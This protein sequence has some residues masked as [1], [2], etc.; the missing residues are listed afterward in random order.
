MGS[1]GLSHCRFGSGETGAVRSRILYHPVP[2]VVLVL[3]LVLRR[4]RGAFN[5]QLRLQGRCSYGM[6]VNNLPVLIIVQAYLKIPTDRVSA[7]AF[8]SILAR[9]SS[10][11]QDSKRAAGCCYKYV[12]ASDPL[13]GTSLPGKEFGCIVYQITKI[14]SQ[15]IECT[16]LACPV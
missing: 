4:R 9:Q 3:V 13:C 10:H 12:H 6:Y 8:K 15:S 16:Y 1:Q 11:M 2:L 7:H 5:V 14:T